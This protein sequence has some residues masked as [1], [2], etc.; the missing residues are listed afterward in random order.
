MERHPQG[1]GDHSREAQG[2]RDLRGPSH[3]N[4]GEDDKRK[5]WRWVTVM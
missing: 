3:S 2:A 5:K 1:Q 4:D